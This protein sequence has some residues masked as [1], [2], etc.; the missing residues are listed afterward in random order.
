MHAQLEG[1]RS[2]DSRARYLHLRSGFTVPHQEI[3]QK[4]YIKHVTTYNV[5]HITTFFFSDYGLSC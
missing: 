3:P 1:D 4:T 5:L 2:V